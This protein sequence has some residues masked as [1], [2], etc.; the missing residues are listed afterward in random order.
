MIEKRKEKVWFIDNKTKILSLKRR[1][2]VEKNI[3]KKSHNSPEVKKN[4]W[5]LKKKSRF[6]GDHNCNIS[7]LQMFDFE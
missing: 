3:T 4:S 2:R 7:P 1:D 5:Y 6:L